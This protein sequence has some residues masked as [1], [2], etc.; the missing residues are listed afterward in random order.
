[1]K[2]QNKLALI[3]GYYISKFDK[4]AYKNLAIGGSTETHKVIGNILDVKASTLKNMRDAFDSVHDN[5]RK[6]WHQRPLPPSREKVLQKYNQYSEN[7]M[8]DVIT[9]I[10]YPANKKIN[11]FDDVD[12]EEINTKQ[13]EAIE[14]ELLERKILSYKRNKKSADECKKRDGFACR[15]CAFRYE[16]RIV[17]CHHLEP[18]HMTKET[19]INIDNLITLCPTCHRLAHNLLRIDYD[20]YIIKSLLIAALKKIRSN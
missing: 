7:E 9:A 5:P 15:A 20:Q 10:L 12:N 17:E 18:L 1:M 19:V 13:K 16:D 4:T 14:G 6:G 11:V 2:K 8:L 3:V